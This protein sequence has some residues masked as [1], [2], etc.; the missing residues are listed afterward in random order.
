MS[1]ARNCRT[2]RFLWR[3]ETG[4]GGRGDTEQRLARVNAHPHRK[5]SKMSCPT[6]AQIF[7][8]RTRHTVNL[9]ACSWPAPVSTLGI[10]HQTVAHSPPCSHIFHRRV[11]LGRQDTLRSHSVERQK[12]RQAR[13]VHG[14]IRRSLRCALR[15][16]CLRPRDKAL[17]SV[18]CLLSCSTVLRSGVD[19]TPL[20]VH[21]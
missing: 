6:P 9:P 20:A 1:Q 5:V 3:L 11:A 8:F 13:A 21:D 18:Q 12:C 17:L 4:P 14:K 19:P 2:V 16:R 15:G 10:V 7:R